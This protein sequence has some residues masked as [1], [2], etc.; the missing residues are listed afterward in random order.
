MDSGSRGEREGA[1]RR[2]ELERVVK[3]SHQGGN[4]KLFS[5]VTQ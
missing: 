5:S 1:R 2:E 3:E 4:K